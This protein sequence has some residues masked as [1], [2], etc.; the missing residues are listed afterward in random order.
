LAI[1]LAAAVVIVRLAFNLLQWLEAVWAAPR[2]IPALIAGGG[3]GHLAVHHEGVATSAREVAV[4][5]TFLLPTLDRSIHL[6]TAMTLGE[7]VPRWYSVIPYIVFVVRFLPRAV[8][9]PELP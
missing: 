2:F 1:T 3:V 4:M 7:E 5:D 6:F 8:Q 9:A